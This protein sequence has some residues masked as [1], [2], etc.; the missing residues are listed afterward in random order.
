VTQKGN[1]SEGTKVGESMTKHP[2]PKINLSAFWVGV[3]VGKTVVSTISVAAMS[4]LPSS[5]SIAVSWRTPALA[6]EIQNTTTTNTTTITTTIINTTTII[7]ER[8]SSDERSTIIVIVIIVV[9]IVLIIIVAI[10]LIVI[11]ILVYY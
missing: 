11:V 5:S 2:R 4:S 6:W 1:K 9:V 10:I 8:T 7:E 3:S